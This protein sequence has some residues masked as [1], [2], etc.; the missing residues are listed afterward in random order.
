MRELADVMAQ[1]EDLRGTV[2]AYID[3]GL[4]VFERKDL[5]EQGD[6]LYLMAELAAFELVERRLKQIHGIL[7]PDLPDYS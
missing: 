1:V 2:D 7:P 6:F 4:I 3:V 5:L